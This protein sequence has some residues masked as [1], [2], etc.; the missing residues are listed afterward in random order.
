MSLGRFSKIKMHFAQLL[1]CVWS[2]FDETYTTLGLYGK[3]GVVV[4]QW[5]RAMELCPFEGFQILPFL[6][7]LVKDFSEP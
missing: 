6:K 1:L 5:P 7:I 4:E 3:E 2:Y